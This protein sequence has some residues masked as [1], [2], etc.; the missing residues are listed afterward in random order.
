[1]HWLSAILGL[2]LAWIILFSI[3]SKPIVSYSYYVQTPINIENISELDNIMGA[4]GLQPSKKVE[5]SVADIAL[6]SSPMEPEVSVA[7]IASPTPVDATNELEQFS[8]PSYPDTMTTP[9]PVELVPIPAL[10]P[11]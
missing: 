11:E 10:V 5:E 8:A 3:G 1:M 6:S 7:D 9:Q 4:V 2:L